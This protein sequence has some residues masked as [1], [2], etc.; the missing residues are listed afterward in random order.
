M[1]MYKTIF[2]SEAYN[3][4]AAGD[5]VQS[6][7]GEVLVFGE[8]A[9]ASLDEAVAAVPNQN[10]I[11]VKVASGKYDGFTVVN[12]DGVAIEASQVVAVDFNGADVMVGG[13]NLA[14]K[15]SALDPIEQADIISGLNDIKAAEGTVYVAAE[16]APA[17]ASPMFIGA[18]NPATVVGG[19]ATVVYGNNVDEVAFERVFVVA[20]IIIIDVVIFIILI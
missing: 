6:I 19:S 9:F 7:S 2:W 8:S 10:A 14:I 15:A 18:G 13:E 1:S 12:Q 3:D 20:I 5:Q 17:D 4:Y 11:I 16:Y